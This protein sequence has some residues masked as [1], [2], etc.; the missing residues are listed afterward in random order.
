MKR[1]RKSLAPAEAGEVVVDLEAAVAAELESV[2]AGK[3]AE[4]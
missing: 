1:G 3:R 2:I 4:I